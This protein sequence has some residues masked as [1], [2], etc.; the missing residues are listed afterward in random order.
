MTEVRADFSPGSLTL[1]QVLF[2]LYQ[3]KPY[4]LVLLCDFL[5]VGNRILEVTSCF[6]SYFKSN[7]IM[8]YL[9][10]IILEFLLQ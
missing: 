4:L 1:H 5:Y 2:P 8:G 9:V 6:G 3:E 7:K 10:S